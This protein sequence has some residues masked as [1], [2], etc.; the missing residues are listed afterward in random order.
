MMNHRTDGT[1]LEATGFGFRAAETPPFIDASQY[2]EAQ[3]GLN[4]VSFPAR[5][6]G[7]GKSRLRWPAGLF[8]C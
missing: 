8:K 1:L 7:S 6:T 5:G 2:L 3:R 4:P